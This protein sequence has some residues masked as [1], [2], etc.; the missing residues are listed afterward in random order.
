M[1]LHLLNISDISRLLI[2]YCTY[3]F[4]NNVWKQVF[5]QKM[6]KF[7]ELQLEFAIILVILLYLIIIS[8]LGCDFVWT[9]IFSTGSQNICSQITA[10]NNVFFIADNFFFIQL[11]EEQ[12]MFFKIFFVTFLFSPTKSEPNLRINVFGRTSLYHVC[13]ELL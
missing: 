3:V 5:D 12:F 10:C 1:H 8:L 11:T 4:L 13:Y 2:D 6:L 9:D 7:K